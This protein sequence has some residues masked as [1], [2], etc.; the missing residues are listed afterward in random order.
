MQCYSEGLSAQE[1]ELKSCERCE[2]AHL[3]LCMTSVSGKLLRV[4]PMRLFRIQLSRYGI[5]APKFTIGD[6]YEQGKK[7]R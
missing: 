7:E 4:G 6:E 2:Q 5:S 1:R 3:V